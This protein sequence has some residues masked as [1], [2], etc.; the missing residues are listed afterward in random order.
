MAFI[1]V[2]DGK[3]KVYIL[4]N[5]NAPIYIGM[6]SNIGFRISS[7]KRTKIFTHYA[8]LG[9]FGNKQDALFVERTLIKFI[10]FCDLGF[11]N[12]KY[13]N[14]YPNKISIL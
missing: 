8:I 2:K 11:E 6:T 5:N 12:G 13:S 14:Y 3:F 9:C 1:G 7:H 4:Y 10:S